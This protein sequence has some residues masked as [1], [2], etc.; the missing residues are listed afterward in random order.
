MAKVKMMASWSLSRDHFLE[1]RIR[2]AIFLV[3]SLL[4]VGIAILLAV[5]LRSVEEQQYRRHALG[6]PEAR[7]R[8]QERHGR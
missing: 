8:E 2:T 5:K 6:S 7:Q 4:F 1:K 3:L